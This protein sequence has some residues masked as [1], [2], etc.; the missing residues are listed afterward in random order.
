MEEFHS[1]APSGHKGVTKTYSK[2]RQYFFWDNMKRDVQ[3][4]IQNCL[5]CQ[6]KKLVRVKNRQPMTLIDTPGKAFDKI[7]M[8]MVGPLPLT[9]RYNK[10]L[11]TIQDLLT[12]YSLAIPIPDGSAKTIAEAFLNKFLYKFGTPKCL[13]TDQGANLTG[14]VVKN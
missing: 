13:F 10:Y 11:L 1:A 8:D 4:F 12:K 7:S 3:N 14:G 6:L 9:Y 5:N 2:I